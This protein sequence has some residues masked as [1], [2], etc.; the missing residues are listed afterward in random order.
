MS[1]SAKFASS[2][3]G[4]FRYCN[5]LDT[6]ILA[7][8]ILATLVSL[9]YSMYRNKVKLATSTSGKLVLINTFCVFGMSI[10]TSNNQA[11]FCKKRPGSLTL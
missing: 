11:T 7:I 2:F 9:R 3:F 6:L 4:P 1:Y 8:F 10:C 5:N